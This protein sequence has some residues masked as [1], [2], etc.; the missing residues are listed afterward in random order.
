MSK[1]R[2]ARELALQAFYATEVSR[3]NV[4]TAIVDWVRGQENMSPDIVS[5]AEELLRLAYEHTDEIDDLI[6]ARALNWDFD[7]IAVLDKLIIRQA[8]CEF[9][10]FEDIPPKVSIDEAIEVSKKFSTENS[11]KFINGILDSVLTDLRDQ[12]RLHKKGRGL[13]E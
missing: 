13:I 10:Y 1:R 6:K 3:N 11:G 7:R 12:N 9:I 2:R 8:I 4:E 5:F